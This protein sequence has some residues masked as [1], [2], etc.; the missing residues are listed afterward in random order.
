[1][2]FTLIGYPDLFASS[3]WSINTNYANGISVT[4]ASP[5][6][7]IWTFTAGVDKQTT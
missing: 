6:Q 3:V 1:M 2:N 7:H 5:W 4:H